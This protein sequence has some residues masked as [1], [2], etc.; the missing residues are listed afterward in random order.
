MPNRFSD[1]VAPRAGGWQLEPS[2][3]GRPRGMAVHGAGQPV[4]ITEPAYRSSSSH[5]CPM[6]ATQG[7]GLRPI[8]LRHQLVPPA[9]RAPCGRPGHA[10]QRHRRG[11]RRQCGGV[12]GGLFQ[13]GSALVSSP[14]T[15]APWSRDD[16]R[17]IPHGQRAQPHPAAGERA[18]VQHCRRVVLRVRPKALT[19]STG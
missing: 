13:A 2:S 18:I 14:C 19:G 11:R 4:A 7:G 15:S 10:R 12:G 1:D 16:G 9:A 5:I 8:F 6:P 3:D 17:G